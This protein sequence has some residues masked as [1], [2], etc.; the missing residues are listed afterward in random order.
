[1]L[2]SILQELCFKWELVEELA[3]HVDTRT[4]KKNKQKT[5]KENHDIVIKLT[6]V[7]MSYYAPEQN[8]TLVPLITAS[9]LSP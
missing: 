3:S 1:M 2:E 4:F 5:L 6:C 8:I 7:Q 9:H